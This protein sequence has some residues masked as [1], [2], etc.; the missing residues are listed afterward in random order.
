MMT[1]DRTK[2]PVYYTIG[3]DNHDS[4]S[5]LTFVI[6]AVQKGWFN[7][8]DILVLDNAMIHLH[9]EC[10]DLPDILWNI[11]GP[12][13]LSMCI[14]VVPLP[15]RSPELNPKELIWHTLV[16][17]LKNVPLYIPRPANHAVAH[18]A[19]YIL[20]NMDHELMINSA[21]HCGY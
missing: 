16:R 18:Y 6:G 10:S 5:F 7:R 17:R 20:D 14:S 11:P 4:F 15:T 9:G 12:D 21:I 8:Y 13:G 1:F 3:E 2:P 19:K